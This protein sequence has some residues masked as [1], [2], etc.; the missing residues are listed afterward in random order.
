[1]LA[2]NEDG[3]VNSYDGIIHDITSLKHA[4][5]SAA[6]KQKQLIQADKMVSLGILVSGIAH[7]INNPNNFIMLN[8]QFFFKGL[9]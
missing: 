2:K 4:E 8:A 7:E 3:K 5:E 6:L 9:G 1:V